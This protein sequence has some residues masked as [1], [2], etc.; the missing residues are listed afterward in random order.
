MASN[1]A[2]PAKKTRG[3]KPPEEMLGLPGRLRAVYETRKKEQGLRQQKLARQSGVSQALISNLMSEPLTEA[4]TVAAL[5]RVA[6]ALNVSLDY[7]VIGVGLEI[8]T[9][10]RSVELPQ[11]EVQTLDGSAIPQMYRSRKPRQLHPAPDN[12]K[13]R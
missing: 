13:R 2:T 10:R 7:L 5:A 8:P 1:K 4:M 12:S 3:A 9:L 6:M 11:G